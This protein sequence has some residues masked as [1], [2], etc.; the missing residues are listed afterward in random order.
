MKIALGGFVEDGGGL[1]Q[2]SLPFS[3]L[4]NTAK[5]VSF[6]ETKPKK[7]QIRVSLTNNQEEPEDLHMGGL[8]LFINM[9]LNIGCFEVKYW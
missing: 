1:T 8:Q 5:V 6:N 9:P 3:L 4:L 7:I 2:N